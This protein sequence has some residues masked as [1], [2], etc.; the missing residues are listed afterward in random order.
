MPVRPLVLVG[1]GLGEGLRLRDGDGDGLGRGDDLPVDGR[2]GAGVAP[3]RGCEPGTVRPAGTAVPGA[4]DPGTLVTWPGPAEWN[5]PPAAGWWLGVGL[6]W[7]E[8]TGSGLSVN[9]EVAGTPM[10]IDTV[11]SSA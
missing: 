4:A 6:A 1:D 11:T 5:R 3:G 9:A 2:P 10:C 7:A 8:T